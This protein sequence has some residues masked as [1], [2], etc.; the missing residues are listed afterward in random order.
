MEGSR[1]VDHQ[2]YPPSSQWICSIF[3]HP[4]SG[5]PS[6]IP[7]T[8]ACKWI[9]PEEEL[10]HR[11]KGWLLTLMRCL[12]G[13]SM[14]DFFHNSDLPASDP[15]GPIPA[16]SAISCQH[17]LKQNKD[18]KKE[19]TERKEEREREREKRERTRRKERHWKKERKG[20]QERKKKRKKR[21]G[22]KGRK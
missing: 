13:S 18:G 7:S 22:T 6:P 12:E 19:K 9:W 21:K 3:H 10:P 17:H 16:M 14:G 1:I 8:P 20:K 15:P 11:A 5:P 2:P 4:I